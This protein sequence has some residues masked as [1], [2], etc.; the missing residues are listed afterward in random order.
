MAPP[1]FS[2]IVWVAEMLTTASATCSTRSARLVGRAWANAGLAGASASGAPPMSARAAVAA[3]AERTL[4]RGDA[5]MRAGWFMGI[6]LEIVSK[7]RRGASPP[8]LH[9]N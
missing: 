9:R 8:P 7:L 5:E 3:S 4:G 6:L 1:P 2:S